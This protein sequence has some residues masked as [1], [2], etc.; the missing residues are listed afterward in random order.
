MLRVEFLGLLELSGVVVDR[1]KEGDDI[2]ALCGWEAES[3]EQK[4]WDVPY[5]GFLLYR[6]GVPGD[7]MGVCEA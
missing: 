7:S 2:C 4:G 5:L 1:I 3:V 6:A